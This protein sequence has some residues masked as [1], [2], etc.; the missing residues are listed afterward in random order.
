MNADRA[1][2][3]A[4][5]FDALADEFAEGPSDAEREKLSWMAGRWR[6]APG[7]RVLEP[8]C[9]AGYV[10]ALLAELVAPGGQVVAL[11]ISE[12]MLEAARRRLA[13]APAAREATVCLL[14]CRLEDYVPQEPASFDAVIAYRV[15]PHLDDMAR[16]LRAAARAL[17]P[18]CPLFIDHSASRE[19][20]NEFHRRAG[21]AVASDLLPTRDEL[22]RLLRDAGLR[23]V[24][25]VDT[26]ELY[27]VEA[28]KP[29][30]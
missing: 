29:A 17:K 23:M 5:F 3:K 18:G 14:R 16:G 11:D 27:H 12:R 26:D 25:L 21:G 22:V 10:T 2:D 30:R 24:E 28:R 4:R 8:G 1:G 19:K 7:M 6:L 13:E 20:V 15:L 9:G